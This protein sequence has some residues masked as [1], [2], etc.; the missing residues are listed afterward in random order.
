M[1]GIR[2]GDDRQ[3][4][5]G[6]AAAALQLPGLAAANHLWTRA[7][8]TLPGFGESALHG[9][10]ERFGEAVL[11]DL[12]RALLLYAVVPGVLEELVFRGLLFAG[13][14]RIAG[15]GPA[16]LGSALAFGAVH[17]DAHH[18]AIAALLGLQLAFVRLRGGLRLAIFAHVANNAFVLVLRFLAE[19]DRWPAGAAA[20]GPATLALSLVVAG[21]AWAALA[22]STGSPDDLGRSPQ[23]P[24]QATRESDE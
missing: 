21:S 16:I 18:A 2:R 10:L 7:A 15:T 23:P 6:L 17:A 8:A 24:L 1:D 3:R 13:L 11:A 14:R 12:A 19:T 20:D 4:P 9:Q 5:L 22:Q